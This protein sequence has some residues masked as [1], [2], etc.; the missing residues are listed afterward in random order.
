MIQN[1][2]IGHC[3]YE[4]I[5]VVS[6]IRLHINEKKNRFYFKEFLI[7]S[8]NLKEIDN[9]IDDRSLDQNGLTLATNTGDILKIFIESIT[10]IK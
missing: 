3:I 8:L 6:L 9:M 1:L 2:Y 10:R 4:Y 5:P 7:P